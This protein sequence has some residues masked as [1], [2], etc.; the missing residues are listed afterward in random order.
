MRAPLAADCLHNLG[1]QPKAHILGHYLYFFDAGE[2]VLT[3]I[4]DYVFDQYFGG[5][6]ARRNRYG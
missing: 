4:I 5:G 3:Q 1:R 6:C 2:T